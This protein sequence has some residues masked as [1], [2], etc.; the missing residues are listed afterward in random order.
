MPP[1]VKGRQVRQAEFEQQQADNQPLIAVTERKAAQRTLELHKSYLTTLHETAIGL[2][3]RLEPDKVLDAMIEGAA[4]I[5]D[6]PQAVD[7]E[8]SLV[9]SQMER[10]LAMSGLQLD[11]YMGMIGK[12]RESY[13]QELRPAAEDRLKRRLVLDQVA[14]LERL[15]DVPTARLER[16]FAGRG[17]DVVDVDITK[18]Y[19]D[20]LRK[21]FMER[22][23]R[24]GRRSR[25]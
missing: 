19:V 23:G 7:R 14:A 5:E 8:G 24:R 21:F 3:S 20:P 10:N 2:V 1:G 9:L 13:M 16:L 15:R 6:P 18:S 11:T 12:T 4:Q 25:R 22:E 17:V